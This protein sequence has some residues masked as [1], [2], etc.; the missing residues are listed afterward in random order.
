MIDEQGR[1]GSDLSLL[2]DVLLDLARLERGEVCLSSAGMGQRAGGAVPVTFGVG[3]GCGESSDVLRCRVA[4]A[5][6]HALNTGGVRRLPEGSAEWSFMRPGL[7]LGKPLAMFDVQEQSHI[8]LRQG[9]LLHLSIEAQP[10]TPPPGQVLALV[11]QYIRDHFAENLR[12]ATVGRAVAVSPYYI[13]HLFQRKR[14]T[15]FLKYLTSVRMQHGR[16]FLVETDL[17]VEAIAE[18]VG[19]SAAKRFREVFKRTYHLTPSEYRRQATA[20][21]EWAVAG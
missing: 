15:T 8:T 7:S 13:S 5:V 17:P 21:S 18:R 1:L 6:L 3:N 19:Y 11:E 20:R 9:C 14:D 2:T 4:S 12:L 10:P 16:R